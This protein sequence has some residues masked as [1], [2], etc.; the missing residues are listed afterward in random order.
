MHE[1]RA[2][3]LRADQ[4]A[5]GE[6]IAAQDRF[7]DAQVECVLVGQDQEERAGGSVR[8]LALDRVDRDAPNVRRP[9]RAERGR[10]GEAF[11]ALVEPVD[12]DVERREQGRD[13]AADVAGAVQL[14]VKQRLAIGPA[15]EHR[16]VERR[17]RQRDAAAAALAERRSEGER[18]L[19]RLRLAAAP[20][21]RAPR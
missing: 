4:A 10:V 19:A 3:G 7:D 17:E 15:L 8:D 6:V 11:V 14:E 9:G 20:A 12:G 13:R 18:L 1:A 16:R 2:L 21:S 5:E